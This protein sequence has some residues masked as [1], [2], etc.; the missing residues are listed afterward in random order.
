MHAFL[1]FMK[2][3]DCDII[4]NIKQSLSYRV[5]SLIH[6]CLIRHNVFLHDLN[7]CSDNSGE[8]EA[9]PLPTM[10]SAPTPSPPPPYG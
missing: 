3:G 8:R 5:S 1:K 6:S 10:D 7:T 4:L 9:S 2:A